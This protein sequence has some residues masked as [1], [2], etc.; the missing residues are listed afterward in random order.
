MQIIKLDKIC[1]FYISYTYHANNMLKI[2]DFIISNQI[3]YIH[4]PNHT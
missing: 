4:S 2:F 1:K 3:V